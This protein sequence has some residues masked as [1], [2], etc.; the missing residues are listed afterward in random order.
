MKRCADKLPARL[1]A[2]EDLAT[3]G[4]PIIEDHLESAG[5]M[6]ID[7]VQIITDDKGNE[8]A[9]KVRRLAFPDIAAEET[10]TAF[11]V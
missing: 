2:L 10:A 9:V 6:V 1:K 5:T 4:V 7:D 8:K 11:S 3:S